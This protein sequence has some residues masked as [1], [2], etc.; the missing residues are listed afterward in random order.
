MAESPRGR[1]GRVD[2][3]AA[4]A[5]PILEEAKKRSRRN[6]SGQKIV[7]VEEGKQELFGRR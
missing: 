6:P 3:G 4:F 5:I 7:G 1:L 2:V